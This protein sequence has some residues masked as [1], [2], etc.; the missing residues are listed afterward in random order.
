MRNHVDLDHFH[1]AAGSYPSKSAAIGRPTP[2]SSCR[3]LEPTNAQA[4]AMRTMLSALLVENR[5][6]GAELP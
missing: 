1:S 3:K 6:G 5:A 2:I 4:L